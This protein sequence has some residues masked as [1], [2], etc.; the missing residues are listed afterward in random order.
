MV[1]KN[2]FWKVFELTGSITAYLIY[3]DLQQNSQEDSL[4]NQ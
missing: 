1:D 2:F 3:R 4:V